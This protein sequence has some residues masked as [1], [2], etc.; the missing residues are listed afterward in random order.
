MNKKNKVPTKKEIAEKLEI[1]EQKILETSSSKTK[2]VSASNKFLLEIED[3]LKIAVEKKVSFPQ[4]QRDIFKIFKYRVSHQTIRNFAIERLGY[5]TQKKE[6][7]I[8]EKYK[9]I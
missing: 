5:Q 7:S 2:R 1:F 9:D 8:A 3:V 4:I 6:K